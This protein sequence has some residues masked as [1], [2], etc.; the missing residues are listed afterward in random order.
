[1]KNAIKRVVN[2]LPTPIVFHIHNTIH[3]LTGK[4]GKSRHLE[5]IAKWPDPPIVVAGPFKGMVFTRQT[6][7]S[8][9]VPSL[10]GT[11]EKEIHPAVEALCN[12]GFDVLADIGAGEGYYA[13]GMLLKNKSAITIGYEMFKPANH[14][15][16]RVAKLN[17]VGNRLVRPGMCTAEKLSAALR[18]AKRPAVIC[19]CEGAE[20][21]L[22]DPT[23]IPELRRAAILVE[24]HDH[25]RAG[26]S[27]RVRERFA[28]THD[29][30]VYRTTGRSMSDLPEGYSMTP[31]ELE[32]LVVEHRGVPQ[33]FYLL[34][35]K[36]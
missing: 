10:L 16:H 8:A 7:S 20:D 22:L 31:R 34:M 17:G 30:T 21:F 13:V 2:I 6:Y 25:E 35:P 23:A 1:M 33:L 36:A 18:K 14:V 19:D 24:L 28:S 3:I 4:H 12:F 29:V 9:L 15:L 27:D 32:E 11:Y 26:V 5:Y